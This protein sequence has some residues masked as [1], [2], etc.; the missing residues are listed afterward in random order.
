MLHMSC[1]QLVRSAVR[2]SCWARCKAP[3]IV[4]ALLCSY[5][6]RAVPLQAAGHKKTWPEHTLHAPAEAWFQCLGPSYHNLINSVLPSSHVAT[7]HKGGAAPLL[8][9]QLWLGMLVTKP[10]HHMIDTLACCL[11]LAAAG[12]TAM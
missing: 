1:V 3:C 7:I 8:A 5:N 2:K 4:C 9:L 11:A 6:G 12:G 10:V